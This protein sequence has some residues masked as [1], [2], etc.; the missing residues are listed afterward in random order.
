MHDSG[1]VK[2]SSNPNS[3]SLSP[4]QKVIMR[5]AHETSTK[6]MHLCYPSTTALSVMDT[7][8]IMFPNCSDIIFSLPLTERGNEAELPVVQNYKT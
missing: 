3:I 6:R 2:D 4:T 7:P 8:A 5:H 1:A